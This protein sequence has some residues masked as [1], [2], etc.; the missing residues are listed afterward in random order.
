[1]KVASGKGLDLQAVVKIWQYTEKQ[2]GD[3]QQRTI[4]YNE[5]YSTNVADCNAIGIWLLLISVVHNYQRRSA[6]VL[7]RRSTTEPA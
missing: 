1:M 7:P 2:H 6:A 5:L 4:T 3:H